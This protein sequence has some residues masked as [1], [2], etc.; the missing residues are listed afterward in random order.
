MS[1]D[2]VTT[3]LVNQRMADLQQEAAQRRLARLTRAGQPRPRPWWEP[4][5]LFR[6]RGRRAAAGRGPAAATVVAGGSP[7]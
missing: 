6:T 5:M 4:L 3:L 1:N 7:C 2:Y